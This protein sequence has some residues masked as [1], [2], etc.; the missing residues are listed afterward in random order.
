MCICTISILVNGMF[1]RSHLTECYY[2][3]YKL[4][5]FLL[6]GLIVAIIKNNLLSIPAGENT[7]H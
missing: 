2:Y 5:K 7:T 4:Y 6:N 3:Y 1:L